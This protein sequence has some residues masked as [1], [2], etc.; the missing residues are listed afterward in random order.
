MALIAEAWLSD[1]HDGIL[2]DG[3]NAMASIT[4]KETMANIKS[5]IYIHVE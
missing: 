5:A 2:I 3:I 4:Y 1:K